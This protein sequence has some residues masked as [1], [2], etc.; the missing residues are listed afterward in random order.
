MIKD[1]HKGENRIKKRKSTRKK[2]PPKRTSRKPRKPKKSRKPRKYRKSTR[3][4]KYQKGGL[5]KINPKSIIHME[6]VE[7][8]VGQEVEVVLRDPAA[9]DPD[10]NTFPNN[11]TGEGDSVFRLLGE[12]GFLQELDAN[13]VA[14]YGPCVTIY[15]PNLDK[16][17]VIEVPPTFDSINMPGQ[18]PGPTQHLFNPIDHYYVVIRPKKKRTIHE[19]S[20]RDLKQKVLAADNRRQGR[21]VLVR[22]AGGEI[23]TAKCLR[24]REGRITIPRDVLEKIAEQ[25]CYIRNPRCC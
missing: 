24:N 12:P 23:E 15:Y 17:V 18:P 22:S 21:E 11:I 16:E 3:K 1:K 13:N 7:E 14:R 4:Y 9:G 6:N 25:T 20:S 10:I 5:L 2:N 8:H 19:V